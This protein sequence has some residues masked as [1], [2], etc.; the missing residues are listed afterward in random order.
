MKLVSLSAQD[1]IKYALSLKN[2]NGAVI[3]TDSMDVL[4]DNIELI[5]TFKPFDKERMDEI[6]MS[7]SPFFKNKNL[8]WMHHKYHDGL[9][10]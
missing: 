8:E 5:R 4:K 1:L 2:V 10:V 7:L 9:W 6:R 3:G